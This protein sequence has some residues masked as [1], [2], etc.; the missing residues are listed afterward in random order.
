MPRVGDVVE[1]VLRAALEAAPEELAERGGRRRGKSAEV[2]LG[3]QHAGERVAD[4]SAAKSDR[5]ESIS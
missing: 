1:A 2:D 3:L 4:V 5:P